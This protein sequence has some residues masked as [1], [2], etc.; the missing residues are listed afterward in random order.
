MKILVT[1]ST[2]L[3]GSALVRSLNLQGHDVVRLLRKRQN[4]AEACAFWDYRKN[5]IE[6]EKLEGLDAVVH[7]AGENIASGLWSDAKKKA[8]YNSRIQG[9]AFLS[10]TLAELETPPKAMICAS[11]IGYYGSKGDKPLTEVSDKGTG[12]LAETCKDWENAASPA[13]EAGI[14]VAYARLGI[15]LSPHGGALQLMYWP[16]KL[17]LAGNLGNGKQYMSWVMLDD[18]VGAL[19]HLVS[20]DTLSGPVNVVAPEPVTNAE[21]TST[22]RKTLIPPFLPMHYWTPPA[23]A[24]IISLLLGGLGDELLLASANVKPIRLLETGY[25]FKYP[26][27][28]SALKAVL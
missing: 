28:K 4:F 13:K 18:V 19:S 21:F 8:I 1:G 5:H 11:A 22:M 12:F 27:L 6:A 24:I 23:P 20:N 2:G 17:G 9:T 16:F 3:V 7:L 15:V 10:K 14:R 26:Q 25:Q